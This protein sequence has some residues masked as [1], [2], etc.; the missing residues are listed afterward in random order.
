MIQRNLLSSANSLL[1]QGWHD[2]NNQKINDAIKL[3]QQLNKQY[4]NNGEAWYFTGQIALAIGNLAAARQSLKNACKLIPQNPA[5]QISLANV[6]LKSHEA[7]Q[8]KNTIIA[9]KN[10]KLTALEHNQVGMLFSQINM[11]PDAVE[12]YQQAINLDPSNNE[13][14]YSLAAVQRHMGGLEQAEDN[15]TRAIALNTLDIDAHTL[16]VDLKKQ[17]RENN[18]VEP[19]EALLNKQLSPKKEV[20]VRFAL[21]KSHEDM[22]EYSRSFEYLQQA[23]LLRRKHIDYDVAHDIETMTQI[24]QSFNLNWWQKPSTEI[25]Q[26][27]EADTETET[28]LTPIFI[29]G[30]PR[31]GSTL[32]D[33]IISAGKNVHSAGELNDFARL[34]T[35]QVE[36]TFGTKMKSRQQF[37]EAS[38]Q[39]DFVKLGQD[40]LHSVKDQLSHIDFGKNKNQFFTDK[41]PFNFLYIGL[42]QKA[43]PNAKIIHVKRNTMDTCYAIFKTLFHQAYPFSYDQKELAEYYI[44]YQKLIKHW[45]QFP[46]LNIHTVNYESLVSNTMDCAKDMVQF[47]GLQ[48]QD[49]FVNVQNNTSAV[50]TASA[51]QIRQ[52]IH[53]KSVNKWRNFEK[54]LNPMITSLEQ[55]G[56]YCD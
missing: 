6:Y 28:D 34:F 5:W 53:K 3:S 17:T 15:L 43:L 44:A 30:M 42:I 40:Y 41:L 14:Y 55:A 12:H 2:L 21:A 26:K 13:H 10:A 35:A 16:R 38:S 48:W 24:S 39:I 56:I 32:T 54:Q 25:Q 52:A 22:A 18:F 27:A 47:C 8:V 1:K 37:I 31:T 7:T 29:L 36:K 20:Q 45:E 49:E 50:N 11:L 4:P 51:S 9:L 46:N 23:S 19:L 33:R